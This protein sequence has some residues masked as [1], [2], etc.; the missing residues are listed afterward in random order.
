MVDERLFQ[1]VTLKN[2]GALGTTYRLVKTSVLRA[3]KTKEATSETPKK[4][5]E[6]KEKVKESNEGSTP[7]AS[8]LDRPSP[9]ESGWIVFNSFTSTV[10]SSSLSDL[11]ELVEKEYTEVFLI[12]GEERGFL[13][14]HSSVTFAIEFSAPVAGTF[15]EEYTLVFDSKIPN[16]SHAEERWTMHCVVF[17]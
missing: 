16:V 2:T 14:P 10:R 15:Q 11:T 6:D 7:C 9:S 3:E 17:V 1:S 13:V 4:E 12:K 8:S 5:I